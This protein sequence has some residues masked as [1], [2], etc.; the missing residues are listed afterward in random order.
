[1]ALEFISSLDFMI[2]DPDVSTPLTSPWMEGCSNYV[3]TVVFLARYLF[4]F[5]R[6]L[7][8]RENFP[9]FFR[10]IGRVGVS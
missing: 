7:Y 4:Q 5:M 1:M 6:V 10:S 9:V 8:V 2:H 3:L